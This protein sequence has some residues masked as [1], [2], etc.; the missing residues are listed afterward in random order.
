VHLRQF[1]GLPVC[2]LNLLC[3]F[4]CPLR[5]THTHTHSYIHTQTHTRT[6]TRTYAHTYPSQVCCVPPLLPPLRCL[7]S[8]YDGCCHHWPW[9]GP[10]QPGRLNWLRRRHLCRQVCILCVSW[11]VC[12]L[13]CAFSYMKSR[14][15]PQSGRPPEV[16]IASGVCLCIQYRM[17]LPSMVRWPSL[18]LIVQAEICV[19]ESV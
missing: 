13:V 15:R 11:C 9:S 17:S 12:I 3:Y 4:V 5:H 2:L 19:C 6:H 10:S 18:G 16:F 7:H 1:V 14:L 8:W